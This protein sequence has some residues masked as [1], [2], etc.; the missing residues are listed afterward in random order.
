VYLGW[1]RPTGCPKSP[2]QLLA[3]HGSS[4]GRKSVG[5]A[6][7]TGDHNYRM[8]ADFLQL[9]GDAPTL[10]LAQRD[11]VARVEC[12]STT[13]STEHRERPDGRNQKPK[14][15]PNVPRKSSRLAKKF[16]VSS[17]EPGRAGVSDSPSGRS[18]SPELQTRGLVQ[19]GFAGKATVPEPLMR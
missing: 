18:L 6:C 10:K 13:E 14:R 16:D 5:R 2:K 11:A 4:S 1:A 9:Q 17:T 7:A 8:S 19:L 12:F 3:V 15:C